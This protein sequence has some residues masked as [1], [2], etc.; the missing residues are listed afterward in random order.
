MYSARKFF[1]LALKIGGGKATQVVDSIL[2]GSPA[3]TAGLQSGDRIV[4]IGGSPI[5]S[6]S[7]IPERISGS[8]GSELT[9]TVVRGGEDVRLGPIRP[10]LRD[11]AYRLGCCWYRNISPRALGNRQRPQLVGMGGDGVCSA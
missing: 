3:A 10:E 11:G 8:E 9:L 6:P 2:P 4:S 7:E 1:W 5:S